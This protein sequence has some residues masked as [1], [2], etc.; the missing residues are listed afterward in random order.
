MH[1]L[2]IEQDTFIIL[3]IEDVLLDLGYT[4][5]DLAATPEA[6]VAAAGTRCPDLI[7]SDIRSC[8]GSGVDT[9]RQ[10]CA[11]KPIPVVFVTAT[12]WEVR[13]I[14]RRAVVVPKPFGED[15]LRDGVSRATATLAD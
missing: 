15:A 12:P 7:T 2:I 3:M 9:V 10:I 13:R 11:G 5:F 8:A 1:A 4:S 14:D 6:A